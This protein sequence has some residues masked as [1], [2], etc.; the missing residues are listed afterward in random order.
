MR[1]GLTRRAVSL[2]AALLVAALAAVA[3]APAEPKPVALTVNLVDDKFVPDR[4][5]LKQG[6]RYQ[7][8]LEN[9]GRHT[10][11]FTAPAFFD[12]VDVD[13]PD[14]LNRE[15]AEVLLQPGE[16]KDVFL[17]ARRPGSYDLRC[18]DHDWEGMVGSI[19]IE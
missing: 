3:A 5:V 2:I 15:R 8:H 12:A 18:A 11:E 7:L 1:E 17:T 14:V 9:N 13:N 10:H 19:I 6:V 16:S 4:L